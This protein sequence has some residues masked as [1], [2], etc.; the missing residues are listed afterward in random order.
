MKI[1]VISFSGRANGA[2]RHIADFIGSHYAGEDV[3]S[4][5]FSDFIISPC[6]GCQNDCFISG[7]DCPHIE[8]KELEILKSVSESDISYFVLPNYSDYPPSNFFAFSERQL[9]WIWG[10]EDRMNAYTNA[11]K[12]FVVVSNSESDNIK[13]ALSQH[14]RGEPEI[15][16]LGSSKYGASSR[17]GD[18]LYNPQ[19]QEDLSK[20]LI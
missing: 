12:R 19:A 5:Y 7:D 13:T 2:S 11:K 14:V 18:L 10:H 3:R 1:T 15:L 4:F 9:C 17:K 8:D 16:L 6:G 20:F